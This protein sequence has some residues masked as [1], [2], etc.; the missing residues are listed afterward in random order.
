LLA[1]MLRVPGRLVVGRTHV[2][3]FMRLDSIDLAARAAGLDRDPGW[4]PELGR[5]VLLHFD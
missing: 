2:D 4:V 1:D 3:L 5:V